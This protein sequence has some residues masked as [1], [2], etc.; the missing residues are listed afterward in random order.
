MID[1]RVYTSEEALAGIGDGASVMVSGFGGAGVPAALLR[2]FEASVTA[3]D[4]TLIAN[5]PRFVDTYAPRLFVERRVVKV[6][7]SAARGREDEAGIYEKQ[8]ARG[9]LEVEISPQGSFS[10]RL[11]AGG[12][13][14]PAF[15]TPT[16][17]GTK[18]GEGKETRQFGGRPCV[19][20]TALTVD[21][22]LLRGHLADRWGNVVFR[23]AQ[24]NFGPAMAAAARVA[25][26]E[27]E[28]ISDAP[29]EPARVEIP[30]IYV[31]RVIA[32]PDA[33]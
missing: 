2:A 12:A 10:E 18:L 3:T 30:G 13:G 28:R 29:L 19:L 1:K 14:I 20:E 16:G 33:R 27:V 32:L 22:A 17:A 8:W 23:G 7:A 11:R 6:I 31:A 24:A 15:Y 26:V 5:S 25:I 4:L 9:E 21:F